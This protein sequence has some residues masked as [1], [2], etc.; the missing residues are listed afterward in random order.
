MKFTNL[1]AFIVVILIS[2]CR[3]NGV[4]PIIEYP[5]TGFYGE[6]VLNK[7]KLN[8]TQ[9]GSSMQ[10]KIPK[11]Q[12]LK[13]RIIGIKEKKSF[14]FSKTWYYG[15]TNNWA[16]SAFD[17]TNM[18]QTFTSIDSGLTSDARVDFANDGTF[19]IEY[20]EN[21]SS[22]PTFTKTIKVSY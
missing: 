6:N 18:Y 21:D 16:V 7:P 22:V 13:I 5:E 4:T 14:R 10:C 9:F 2:S 19:T 15:S 1:S 12:K 3:D 8:F 11:G 17:T 20:Y